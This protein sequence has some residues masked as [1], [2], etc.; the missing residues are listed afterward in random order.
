MGVMRGFNKLS[1]HTIHYPRSVL[2]SGTVLFRLVTTTALSPHTHIYGT[3]PE[4]CREVHDR[5]EATTGHPDRPISG[6]SKQTVDSASC[7][8]FSVSPHLI[9]FH[10]HLLLWLKTYAANHLICSGLLLI[11]VHQGPPHSGPNIVHSLFNCRI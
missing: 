1:L 11:T 10:P 4:T 7:P 9:F 8:L 3:S 6:N 5:K 2:C